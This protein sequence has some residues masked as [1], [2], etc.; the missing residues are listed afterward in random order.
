[1]CGTFITI[2]QIAFPL[3]YAGCT[4]ELLGQDGMVAVAVFLGKNL[5]GLYSHPA[6]PAASYFLR[7]TCSTN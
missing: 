6:P 1:M 7:R 2:S 3:S 5:L 4:K